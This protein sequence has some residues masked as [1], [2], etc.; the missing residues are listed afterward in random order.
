[1][2]GKRII[3]GTIGG[4]DMGVMSFTCYVYGYYVLMVRRTRCEKDRR[5]GV[6]LLC[7]KC[8]YGGHWIFI[9]AIWSF[10]QSITFQ[11]LV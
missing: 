5:I 3:S 7:S 8:V 1:M 9:W 6:A 4:M 10:C 2:E 11:S